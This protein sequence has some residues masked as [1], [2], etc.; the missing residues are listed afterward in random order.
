MDPILPSTHLDHTPE[1]TFTEMQFMPVA[2]LEETFVTHFA[3][4]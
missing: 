3:Q 2:V 1:M 4:D